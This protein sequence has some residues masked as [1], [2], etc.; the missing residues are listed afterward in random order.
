MEQGFHV[1]GAM[2]VAAFVVV[3]GEGACRSIL[4]R[5][6]QVGMGTVAQLYL[7]LT[8]TAT[9]MELKVWTGFFWYRMAQGQRCALAQVWY[10]Y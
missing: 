6:E 7:F 4:L 2:A 1:G 9:I 10:D 8:L 3:G 5:V